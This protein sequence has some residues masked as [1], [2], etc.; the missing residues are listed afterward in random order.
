MYPYYGHY[1]DHVK[2]LKIS[3]I[4][5]KMN[6]CSDICTA[7]FTG[8]ET[9]VDLVLIHC[10]LFYYVNHVVLMPTSIFL[11]KFRPQPHLPSKARTLSPQL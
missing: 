5:I 10:F 6:Q 1:L 3:D 8:S 4:K 2:V 11:A 9:G 7:H